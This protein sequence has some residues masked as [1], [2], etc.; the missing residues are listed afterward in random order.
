MKVLFVCMGNICRSP[1][2][3]GVFRKMVESGPLAGKVDIDSAG[4]HGY[5][6]GAPPDPRAIEHAKQRGYDLTQL[7]ARE[8]SPSD[9]ERFDYVIAMDEL[10]RRHLKSICPTRLQNKIELILEYGGEADE[11]EVPDPY[12]GKPADFE[13]A[14][15][16]I[17]AGCE[18]L[19]E[20]LHDQ[21]KM[22]G[23]LVGSAKD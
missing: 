4:T 21:L 5:H 23:S 20:Y 1:T 3:E 19:H 2:A 22:R 9:F 6:E 8:V 14:L 7:R 10:N 17:E 11:Y 13:T 16:L 15:D 12:H 18:G